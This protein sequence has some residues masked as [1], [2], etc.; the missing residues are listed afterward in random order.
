VGEQI[1]QPFLVD[2][3]INGPSKSVSFV[4]STFAGFRCSVDVRWFILSLSTIC[5]DLMLRWD[6]HKTQHVA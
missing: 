6:N 3:D 5:F 2:E 1:K 4:V